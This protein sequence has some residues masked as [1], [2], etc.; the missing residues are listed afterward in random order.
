M[1]FN[2][3]NIKNIYNK[4]V[5][6]RGGQGENK[7][8]QNNEELIQSQSRQQDALVN[9]P[10]I[11][12]KES[13]LNEP[14]NNSNSDAQSEINKESQ[15]IPEETN[16]ETSSDSAPPSES[17]REYSRDE[18]KGAET[19]QESSQQEPTQQEPTQQEPTQQEPSEVQEIQQN[20]ETTKESSQNQDFNQPA[21]TSEDPNQQ[22]TTEEQ[23]EFKN[24]S[25]ELPP[26][27]PM[28]IP[29]NQNEP[30]YDSIPYK[31]KSKTYNYLNRDNLKTSFSG[32]TDRNTNPYTIYLC[33]YTM[34]LDQYLPFYQYMLINKDNTSYQFPSF[35]FTLP[36]HPVNPDVANTMNENENQTPD[37]DLFSGAYETEL[38]KYY[39]EETI[40]T[41]KGF[42][43]N[44]NII[45]V[46][47]EENNATLLDTYK[48]TFKPAI[49]HEI[50]NLRKIGN[51]AIDESVS[52]L[53][54]NYEYIASIY[55]ET[56]KVVEY[57]YLLYLCQGTEGAYNNVEENADNMELFIPNKILHSALGYC[58][59]FT[60]KM[61]NESA[62][63]TKRFVVFIENALYILNRA[64]PTTE[65]HLYDNVEIEEDKDDPDCR[66]Y[67]YSSVYFWEGDT[68]LWAVYSSKYLFAI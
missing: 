44:K 24:D 11:Q 4:F 33:T 47:L 26:V 64:I 46:I 2:Y 41:F 18:N 51:V 8:I 23:P 27:I 54:K 36:L 7:N 60:S 15:I 9:E 50:I 22:L 21:E 49:L 29:E 25:T 14:Q 12:G 52:N 45:Y 65:Y 32:L 35:E 28:L 13:I 10:N 39:G 16:N 53:F 38:K 31:S 40:P 37:D 68:Q 56:D 19:T 42:V 43:E 57:P 5:K 67:Q 58:Y 59:L 55:D 48:S 61:L 1:N 34:I 20:A 30:Y 3:L 17:L 62:T 66:N 6:I 63:N